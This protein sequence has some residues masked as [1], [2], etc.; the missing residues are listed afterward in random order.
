MYQSLIGD[1]K[2]AIA[3]E[4]LSLNWF[5]VQEELNKIYKHFTN[6]ADTTVQHLSKNCACQGVSDIIELSRSFLF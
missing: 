3:R 5:D 6:L 4:Y 2:E 1:R